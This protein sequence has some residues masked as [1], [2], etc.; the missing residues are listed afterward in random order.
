MAFIH[1]FADWFYEYF[2]ATFIPR[3]CGTR[4]INYETYYCALSAFKL[5]S[6]NSGLTAVPNTM[7]PRSVDDVRR[8]VPPKHHRPAGAGQQA[9]SDSIAI[10]LG[11]NSPPPAN[12]PPLDTTLPFTNQQ[13]EQLLMHQHRPAA[14]L[15]NANPNAGNP[16]E[17]GRLYVEEQ[18]TKFMYSSYVKDKLFPQSKFLE[19]D[20]VDMEFSLDP[21]S[22]CQFMARELNLQAEEVPMWWATQ[23]KGIHATFMHHRNNV[24]KA[25]RNTFVRKW[26]SD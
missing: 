8:R 11:N 9:P 13:L 6:V 5:Q 25:I 4:T 16:M 10:P 22:A 3:L 1:L 23:R 19:L 20:I 24:I 21:H 18:S 14:V 12:L 15:N 7:A 2:A 17:L 26:R